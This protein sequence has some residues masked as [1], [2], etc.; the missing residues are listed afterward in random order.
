M[1]VFEVIELIFLAIFCT[2]LAI[3]MLATLWWPFFRS[4]EFFYPK[5]LF[6]PQ[7]DSIVTL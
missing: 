1:Q 5:T 7:F 3:N 4:G 6:A 2:E